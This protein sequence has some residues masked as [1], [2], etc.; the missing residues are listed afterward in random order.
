MLR[1]AQHDSLFSKE[2]CMEP[3]V[4]VLIE[5]DCIALLSRAS[6]SLSPEVERQIRISSPFQA[7]GLE[8]APAKAGGEGGMVKRSAA[9]LSRSRW[10]NAGEGTRAPRGRRGRMR[11]RA[12]APQAY[13]RRNPA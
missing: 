2:S 6:R 8:P 4:S 9:M 13:F 11:V 7:K 1:F 10:K 5:E 12:P 3:S